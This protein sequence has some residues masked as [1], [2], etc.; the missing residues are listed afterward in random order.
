MSRPRGGF[1]PGVL[2][3]LVAG[4]ALA[5]LVGA[6]TGVL[7]DDDDAADEARR[8]IEDNY[9]EVVDEEAL[10]QASIRGM[11]E[12]LRKRFD[13]RFSHYFTEAQLRRF[14]AATSG[15]FSGVGLAVSEVPEG[16]RVGT[17]YPDT[18]AEK[19]GI[20]VGDLIIE[21]EG[22]SI[23]GVSSDVS[24]ARIKGPPGTEVDLTVRSNDRVRARELTVERAEIQIPAV[25]GELRRAGGQSVAYVRLATFTEGAHGELRTLIERL[26]RRGAKALVLDLR[27]NGGGL[28]NEA[29]LTSSIFVEDGTIASTESR[30]GDRTFPAAG[31]AI[32]P[33]PTVVL[34]NRDS[35]SA[36]EILTAA[37]ADHDLATVVGTR[38]FGKATVQ[39]VIELDA[40]GA[41][42]LTVA[43]YLTADGE[44][45]L[46]EG[47]KPDVRVED[48]PRTEGTDEAL[49]RALQVLAEEL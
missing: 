8:V 15:S 12:E 30:R 13:D 31:D 19:S 16:L 23:A 11:I 20:E 34:V 22:R 29:I 21:V 48:D 39:E 44:S 4:L 3:G 10:D 18:P 26:Y 1:F 25:D 36:S 32:A 49:D 14:E 47:V 2:T 45:I 46:G 37:L 27:G 17:V 33:R 24:T 38:T 41:L 40:G 9:F 6:L 5:A 35:A 28:L 42:D 43:D 7:F